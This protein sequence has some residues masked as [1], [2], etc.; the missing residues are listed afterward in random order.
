[1]QQVVVGV[2]MMQVLVEKLVVDI[3]LALGKLLEE[4]ALQVTLLLLVVE[5]LTQDLAE[6]GLDFLRSVVTGY[7]AQAQTAW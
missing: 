4:L 2:Q 5:Q 7:Q 3:V 6:G 1:M